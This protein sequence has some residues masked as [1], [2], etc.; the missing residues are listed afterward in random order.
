MGPSGTSPGLQPSYVRTASE[1]EGD[2]QFEP[3]SEVVEYY[4][5]PMWRF[6]QQRVGTAYQTG[7]SVLD[8]SNSWYSG[9]YL[10]ETVPTVIYILMRHVVPGRNCLAARS[11]LPR[12]RFW[13]RAG[14]KDRL[15]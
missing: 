5:G 2:T 12:S 10:L 7:A 1:L 13:G 15:G 6:V 11:H 14:R 4:K 9:V 3:R 8:A